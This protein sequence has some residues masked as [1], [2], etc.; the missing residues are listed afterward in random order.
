MNPE[1]NLN[2]ESYAKDFENLLNEFTLETVKV[3]KINTWRHKLFSLY[4]KTEISNQRPRNW[5]K[6]V[7]KR[8][9]LLINIYK[10][11]NYCILSR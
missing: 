1:M 3:C 5:M 7:D 6:R 11:N 8:I 4:F 10:D 9:N 2:F